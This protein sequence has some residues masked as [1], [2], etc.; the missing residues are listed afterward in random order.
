MLDEATER[1][2]GED[3]TDAAV[4]TEAARRVWSGFV[5]HKVAQFSACLDNVT[6]ICTRKKKRAG[7]SKN[8]SEICEVYNAHALIS[9]TDQQRE[10]AGPAMSGTAEADARGDRVGIVASMISG[11]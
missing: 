6:Q 7:F 11:I 4:R 2:L 10:C 8:A 3:L 5:K 1:P 9:E